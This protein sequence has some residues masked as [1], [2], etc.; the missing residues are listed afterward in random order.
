MDAMTNERTKVWAK[1][2]VEYLLVAYGISWVIWI[3]T[4]LYARASGAGD[5]LF[6]ADLVWAMRPEATA[7]AALW[8]SVAAIGATFGP[9]I[10][11]IIASARD[12]AIGVDSFRRR[13]TKDGIGLRWYG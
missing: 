11:G 10:A 9:A 12:G 13:T 1:P 8:V 4:W 2:H 3:G 6:N 5:M 7:T